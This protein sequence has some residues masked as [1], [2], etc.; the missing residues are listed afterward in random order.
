MA[1]NNSYKDA[2]LQWNCQG[3][4]TK[5]KEFNAIIKDINNPL[6]L[7]I[8]E[9][10]HHNPGFR[11][12]I[13]VNGYSG[14]Y[15]RE[16]NYPAGNVNN[17]ANRVGPGWGSAVFIRNDLAAA[18]VTSSLKTNLQVAAVKVHI[19]KK[20]WTIC[21][22][23][24]PGNSLIKSDMTKLVKQLHKPYLILGD[25]NA[26]HTNWY[27]DTHNQNGTELAE[28]LQSSD[29]VVLN[30]NNKTFCST[31]NSETA[32]DLS[33]CSPGDAPS[34][35]WFVEPELHPIDHY[36]IFLKFGSA[37]TTT[38]MPKRYLLKKARWLDFQEYLENDVTIDN[39]NNTHDMVD[40]FV[41]E[42]NAA[43]LQ[44][45]P[46]SN[47]KPFLKPIPWW[48]AECEDAKQ[49]HKSATKR[50]YRIKTLDAKVNMKKLRAKARQTY[51]MA[52]RNSW[53]N[54]VGT[55][56]C[57]TPISTVWRKT[58]S[59]QGKYQQIPS[60]VLQHN[61][62]IVTET[63]EVA[64]IMGNAFSNVSKSENYPNN[65]KDYKTDSENRQIEFGDLEGIYN[66]DFEPYDLN[67]ALK[68]A[69]N[70]APGED[71]ISYEML[72]HLPP[73]MMTFLLSM[74]NHIWKNHD[75][76]D[77]WQTAV[78]LPFPKP[79][80]DPTQVG[81]YR[82][83]ALTSCLCKVM[84]KMVNKRLMHILEPFLTQNQ[85]AFRRMR[86]SIDPVILLDSHIKQSFKSKQHTSAV[87][88]D[89]QKAYD[90]TW[91]YGILKNLKKYGVQGHM[92]HFVYNFLQNRAFKVQIKEVRSV[93][94][95]QEEGVPQGAT[96][97]CSLFLAAINTIK[98]VLPRRVE[99]ILFADDLCI[100]TSGGG[101]IERLNI[102]LQLAIKSIEKWTRTNGFQF[103]PT[104]TVAVHFCKKYKNVCNKEHT[105]I[106]GDRPI[107]QADYAKYLGIIMDSKNSYEPHVLDLKARCYQAMNLMKCISHIK[108]GADRKIL[109]QLYQA[110]IQTKLDYGCQVYGLSNSKV[111]DLLDPVLNQG[112][113]LG[114]GA[115]KS[116]RTTSLNVE[117]GI[118]PLEYRRQY[119]ICKQYLKYKQS[120]TNRM[121]YE[122]LKFQNDP[123]CFTTFA[124]GAK[125]MMEYCSQEIT[126]MKMGVLPQ[127][128]VDRAPTFCKE[129][130][131]MSK[132]DTPASVL[133]A[134][135]EDH[136]EIHNESRFIFTDGSKSE[137][138]AGYAAVDGA[139]AYSYN[140]SNVAS[141]FT[142]ELLAILKALS[143]V[144]RLD[145][146]S[147]V[148]CS[149]SRSSLEVLSKD[150]IDHPIV[151]RI[152]KQLI[153]LKGCGKDVAFCWSPA[154][155]G[156]SGNELADAAAKNPTKKDSQHVGLPYS[157]Y[158]PLV[159]RKMWE[160]WQNDWNDNVTDKLREVKSKVV[161]W[162]N[163]NFKNRR[164]ET[165]V[166]RLR[167]GHSR[168]THEHLM[169]NT[170]PRQCRRCNVIL[171][172]KHI[173]IECPN[174]YKSR[175]DCFS[176]IP[177]PLSLTKILSEGDYFK[178][179]SIV[180]F[181]KQIGMFNKI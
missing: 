16:D 87:F 20:D 128:W 60:P 180:T 94:F 147:F 31:D 77:Q 115:F 43:A 19:D 179:E 17:P 93:A 66:L 46:K 177:P 34:L 117:S 181:F 98:D 119:L 146:P 39:F 44:S 80:K 79:G 141:V 56:N 126:V 25:F 47:G 108:W 139:S 168:I 78:V 83:I 125:V 102:R 21:S 161:P 154:H 178:T 164:I 22:I 123:R 103:S 75:F 54:Y 160:Y 64:N 52:Q 159:R 100:Y 110:L 89:L 113:R 137:S 50:Y 129:L 176:H 82:P 65:F 99:F 127:P 105:L 12:S 62:N 120:E 173:L 73:S 155:V 166:A 90:T 70:S 27:D 92:L 142:A 10:N 150:R 28:F 174:F 118:L 144:S 30:N 112:I 96:L 122:I 42:V 40:F 132:E 29:C 148:I 149:D 71:E 51:N 36:P 61:N 76:P 133:K 130:T 4:K 3:I 13:R 7:C 59:I 91:R 35:S 114:T 6:C 169:T 23:Y 153:H 53:A 32:I 156:I 81:N 55:I 171:S 152:R 116:S 41:S 24:I 134:L 72:R 162:G 136:K 37:V 26:R 95:N 57:H 88:F 85:C 49:D 86:S 106:L 14:Y 121:A 68:S 158:L 63:E 5:L 18:D 172:I 135:F 107:N 111:L 104:K 45:I 48:N 124:E 58:R 11:K 67:E 165:A 84:E 74:C 163:P 157:D 138:H 97:S 101:D 69:G 151:L 170:D 8:Q 33:I 1:N 167:I 109:L 38:R 15:C 143:I 140:I 131:N 2:I 9:T 175:R 145:D